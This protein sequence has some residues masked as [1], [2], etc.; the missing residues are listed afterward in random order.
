MTH[1]DPNLHNLAFVHGFASITCFVVAGILL[2]LLVESIQA[3][4]WYLEGVRNET[5]Q[6][7]IAIARS[8]ALFDTNA[9]AG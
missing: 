4:R 1:N 8:R 9:I 3:R 6:R 2:V 7:A 5:R